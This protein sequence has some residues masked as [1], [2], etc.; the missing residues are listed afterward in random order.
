MIKAMIVFSVISLC[1]L[2]FGSIAIF[3]SSLFASDT[4][5]IPTSLLD[6]LTGTVGALVILIV[7]VIYLTKFILKLVD[8][9]DKLHRELIDKYKNDIEAYKNKEK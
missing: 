6:H 5:V 4:T 9:N 1:S 3:V 8:K 7:G 2:F